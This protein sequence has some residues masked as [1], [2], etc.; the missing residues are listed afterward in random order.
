MILVVVLV[1]KI[2]KVNPVSLAL[3]RPDPESPDPPHSLFLSVLPASRVQPLPSPPCPHSRR[4]C[5]LQT[6]CLSS[7]AEQ[8]CRRHR[9]LPD[10][11]GRS[12]LPLTSMEASRFCCSRFVLLLVDASQCFRA[13]G[14]SAKD[15][16]DFWSLDLVGHYRDLPLEMDLLA[17]CWCW[18][19]HG[20]CLRGVLQ[21][22]NN[23]RQ[24]EE[25]PISAGWAPM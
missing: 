18:V 20:V 10:R 6:D 19:A 16:G 9:L 17:K 11:C 25:R 22:V 14:C 13:M 21:K 4:L 24:V 23:V 3:P 7:S 2:V 12:G 8:T 5:P 1:G 15:G